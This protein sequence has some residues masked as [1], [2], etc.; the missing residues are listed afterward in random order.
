MVNGGIAA[1]PRLLPPFAF[2]A[3]MVNG[4]IAAMPGLLPPF[5]FWAKMVNGGIA[6]M[7]GLLPPFAFWAKM[8]NGG[9]ATLIRGSRQCLGF[10]PICLLD[11][12]GKWGLPTLIRDRGN[13]WA[14][15]PFAF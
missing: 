6:A 8:V 15:A 5:A 9:L 14:F 10:C 3:K 7:L 1:M 2:W 4:G 12:D 13:A 11:L